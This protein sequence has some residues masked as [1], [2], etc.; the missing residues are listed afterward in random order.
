MENFDK[1]LELICTRTIYSRKANLTRKGELTLYKDMS[2]IAVPLKQS[3]NP[4]RKF[5]NY[6]VNI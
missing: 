4:F 6:S 3:G 5:S 2:I 1:I